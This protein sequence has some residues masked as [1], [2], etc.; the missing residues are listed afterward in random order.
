VADNTVVF[1]MAMGQLKVFEQ[2]I[3]FAPGGRRSKSTDQ[4]E[5][6]QTEPVRQIGPG[7][8]H[9]QQFGVGDRKCFALC[10][11]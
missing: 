10:S 9:R 1:A 5:N 4:N 3:D 7:A 8:D 11:V 2:A 6:G